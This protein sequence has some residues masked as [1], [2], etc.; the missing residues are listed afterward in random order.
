M[1]ALLLDRLPNISVANKID[2]ERPLNGV[3]VTDAGLVQALL[4]YGTYDAYY[5]IRESA[6]NYK[7]NEYQYAGRLQALDLGSIESLPARA[8]DDLLLFTSSHHVAKFVPF[9]QWSGHEEWPICGRT[10]GLSANSLIPSYAWNYFADLRAHDTI[11]CTSRAGQQALAN[12]FAS[13]EDSQSVAG[14]RDKFPVRMPLIH[15]DGIETGVSPAVSEH[16]EGF[17]VLSIGRLTASHKADL[18]PF[19]AA[20]LCSESLPASATLILAGDDTQGHIAPDLERFAHTFAS[21][22]KLVVMPGITASVKQ[23]LLQVADVALC[24][25]DTYQET[26]GISVLEAMAAGLPVVAPNWDGYRDIVVHGETGFLAGTQIYPDTGLLNAISMLMDPSFVLGQRVIVDI[27]DM[28]RW[29]AVLAANRT[30]AR[31]MGQD[32]RDRVQ[33]HFSWRAVVHRLEDCWS[34][35]FKLGKAVRASKPRAPI[36]FMDYDQVFAGYPSRRLSP[37]TVIC[38]RENAGDLVARALGGELFSTSPI[39]GFSMDL[40]RRILDLCRS[41]ELITFAELIDKAQTENSG[42]SMVAAQ[43]SRLVKYGLLMLGPGSSTQLT[44]NKEQL[45]EV[46]HDSALSPVGI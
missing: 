33:N 32:G 42:P 3:K 36:G 9:R 23:A 26:F 5:Y 13:L 44:N 16:T 43:I 39:A 2:A 29:I 22:R 20:F 19:I 37:Q 14:T 12:I 38:L 6:E 27:E 35:Q 17:V 8:P 10:H 4:R 28:L 31:Q 15:I 40:D 45:D 30:L 11:I 7:A 41:R 21:S 46:D 18:R 1:R 24:M 34:E 25:S